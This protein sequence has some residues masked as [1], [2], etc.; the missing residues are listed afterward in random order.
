VTEDREV[1]SRVALTSHV[2][3]FAL[4]FGVL[5]VQVFHHLDPLSGV[6][7]HI[8]QVFCRFRVGEAS[9]YR[10]VDVNHGRDV[11]PRADGVDVHAEIVVKR[12]S[13]CRCVSHVCDG[14]VNLKRSVEEEISEG[15][16]SSRPTIKE[17][18]DGF[19][20]PVSGFIHPVE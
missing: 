1:F 3:R 14:F 8:G 7:C 9:A 4:E 10:L 16:T 13:S 2:E 5:D 15:G 19:L 12:S 11:S 20:S 6:L 17:N 18:S